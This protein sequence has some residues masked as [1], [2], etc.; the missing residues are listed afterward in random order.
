MY[1]LSLDFIKKSISYVVVFSIYTKHI[2]KLE[3]IDFVFTQV[4]KQSL[5]FDCPLHFLTSIA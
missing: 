1:I 4:A 5:C 3:R 2:Y